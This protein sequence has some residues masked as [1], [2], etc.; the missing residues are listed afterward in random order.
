MVKVGNLNPLFKGCF[1]SIHTLIVGFDF[2][3]DRNGTHGKVSKELNER[4][5][6]VSDTKINASD[7]FSFI[8]IWCRKKFNG[9]KGMKRCRIKMR[10]G[11]REN[12][13]TSRRK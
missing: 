9:S 2:Q 6:S 1:W 7:N 4:G 11:W 3:K 13:L 10:E 12:G 8:E 5:K